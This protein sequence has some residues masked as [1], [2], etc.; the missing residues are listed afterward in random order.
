[1]L[2]SRVCFFLVF[3]FKMAAPAVPSC[4]VVWQCPTAAVH[5]DASGSV[6]IMEWLDYNSSAQFRVASEKFLSFV[7]ASTAPAKVAL[8]DTERLKIIGLQ[9]QPWVREV[10]LPSLISHGVR[11]IAMVNSLH[12]FTRVGV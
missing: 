10:Y 8:I 9:D 7:Q 11:C 6:F 3:I 2:V 5:V 12:Y 1:M 4:S